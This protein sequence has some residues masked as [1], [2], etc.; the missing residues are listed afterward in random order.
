MGISGSKKEQKG[1]ERKDELSPNNEPIP[2]EVIDKIKKSVCKIKY[3]LGSNSYNGTGFFMNYNSWKFLITNYHLISET[4]KEIEIE[5]WNKNTKILSLNNRYIKYIKK[6]KDIT[7]I[8]IYLNEIKDIVFL[9]Y[10]LNYLKEN[11]YFQ[12]INSNV[13]SLGYPNIYELSCGSGRIKEIDEI[14][15]YEFYHN[16]PTKEGSSGSPII[17]YNLLTVIGVHKSAEKI[18]N[19]NLGT[20]IGELLKEIDSNKNEI[21]VDM[22]L[23]KKKN[24]IICIYYKKEKEPIHLFSKYHIAFEDEEDQKIVNE[25]FMNINGDNIRI[26][27]NNKKTKFSDLYS[28]NEIGAIKVK[29]IFK[30][31]LT[32]TAY[33][34][35]DN[36]N[37]ESIDLTSFNTTNVT[38][39]ASMFSGCYNLKSVNL[40]SFNT[41]NVTDMSFMF[42][43]CHNLK[44][45][46]LSS[47]NTNNVKNM[48]G[49]L[50]HCFCLKSI[51]LSSF[52]TNNVKDMDGIL[53]Y[54]KLKKEKIKINKKCENSQKILKDYENNQIMRTRTFY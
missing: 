3:T 10:D 54:C 8:Q 23:N 46:D 42:S 15:N 22:D 4:I 40:T 37:L 27:I 38:N 34:F 36:D 29:F 39:M 32:S 45:I 53:N 47:F 7:A 6:P 50:S 25:T 51:D 26:Y 12:Y 30:K 24:E 11:G 19:L 41:S 31:L 9:D 17:L 16:I 2:L 20:F 33:M 48:R 5:I 43:H 28:G 21:K 14:D 44:E 35:N 49:M 52:N 1:T 13:I 18:K